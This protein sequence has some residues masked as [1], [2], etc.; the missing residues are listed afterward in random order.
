M[1]QQLSHFADLYSTNST[2]TDYVTSTSQTS[3]LSGGS[4]VALFIVI[5]VLVI[6]AVAGQWKVFK[7]AGQ[8][9]WASIIPFYNYWILL[10]IVGRPTAWIWFYVLSFIPFLNIV[11]VVVSIVVTNDL[12]KSFGKKVG[13]TVLLILLPFIGYP[14]L[15]FGKDTYLG[16]AAKEGGAG[17]GGNVP[18]TVPTPPTTPTETP[19]V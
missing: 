9:G 14:M 7:K 15:G 1:L 5:A 18:P 12:A 4:A 16:P 10:K 13:F 3:Q 19:S 11:S 6:A 8:P 2:S 17:Q